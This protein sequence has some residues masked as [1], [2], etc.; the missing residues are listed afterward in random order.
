M[1]FKP[2]YYFNAGNFEMPGNFYTM[3]A[4][5]VY[6]IVILFSLPGWVWLGLHRHES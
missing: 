6:S 2:K 5:E 3:Q 1:T 4:L